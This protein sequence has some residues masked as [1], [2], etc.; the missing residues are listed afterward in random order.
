MINNICLTTD[1]YKLTHWLQYPPGT[2]RVYSYLESRGGAFPATLF[3][4]LQYYLKQIQGSVMTKQNLMDARNFTEQHLGNA[5]YFNWA[6]WEHIY[7]KHN[8]RLPVEIMAVPEGTLV[9]TSN[10]L[11]TIENTDPMCYWLPNFLET[12]LLKV[13]YP[14]TVATL[15]HSIRELIKSYYEKTG[16]DMSALMFALHD[17]GYRGVSS[18]E[19]AGI[20]G[21]AHLLNFKGTDTIAGIHVVQDIYGAKN[22]PG[23]SIPAAEHS[24]ITSWGKDHEVEAY[25]NMLTQYPTGLVAVVSDSYN[26]YDACEKIWGDLLRDQVNQRPGRLVIRPDSGNPA[27]TVLKVLQILGSKFGTQLNSKGFK[28]LP[29]V[30]RVIQGDGVNYYSIG[31]VLRTMQ[32]DGWAAENVNFGMGGALLQSL[33]RDTCNFAF[34]CSNITRNGKDEAVF[35]LPSTD[36]SK[37]SKPGRLALLHKNGNIYHTLTNADKYTYGNKLEPVFRDGVI[38]RTQHWDDICAKVNAETLATAAV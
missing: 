2:E 9:N 20:G 33:N 28:V 22:M 6:G 17:F 19:S 4:G 8:G 13:W 10:V 21:A 26:I 37:G 1:S 31:D 3:F 24:T 7:K 29:P 12:L 15:S 16:S 14:T 5:K 11:M 23:F 36:T 32:A 30:I 18:E 38:L 25:Q 35:K 34:K 27:T